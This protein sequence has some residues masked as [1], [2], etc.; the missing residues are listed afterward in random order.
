MAG[1]SLGTNLSGLDDWSTSYPFVNQFLMTRGWF[2]Q[3]ATEWD[4]GDAGLLD[5]DA[6]GWVRGFTDD[7]TAPPFQN[8]ASIWQTNGT[9]FRPGTYVLDWQGSGDVSISGNAT[10]LSQTDG[11]I[12]FRLNGPDAVGISLNSTDPGNTGDYVRDM[13]LYHADD[14]D[15]IEAGAIFNPA[16][17]ERIEDFRVLRFMDWGQTNN[18]TV[19]GIAD[20][21]PFD[22]ARQTGPGGASLELMVDLANQTRADAWFTIPHLADAA[23]IRTFATYVRDHL[24]PG[25]MARFEY[26]NE[27]WNWGFE[28]A[29]WAQQ[30]AVVTWGADVEGGWMQ[31]YGRQ[32]TTMAL[33]V[34]NVFGAE[35]GTRALNVF[36]TQSGW[37]GLEGYALDAPEWVA[38]GGL[39]PRDAP[40]H[41]YAIAPYFSGGVGSVDNAAQVDQWIAMGDAG[42]LAAIVYIRSG[43]DFDSL[44][45][46][47]STIAYHAGVAAASAGRLRLMRPGSTS[48][49]RKG[50]SAAR[51]TPHRP[52]SSSTWCAGPSFATCTWNTS[53]SGATRAAG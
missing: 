24:D 32:A 39:T 51:R 18:S 44:A 36:A 19:D 12:T 25:L 50:C 15:L 20:L 11:R 53:R 26:S 6:N 47:G 17:L 42:F 27:V 38:D 13:R 31:W 52:R 16:F 3:S 14:A 45:N 34:A 40:F 46:I 7:G 22:A 1:P 2:T 49:I 23:Y 48:S 5:L 33:I 21:R 35:T 10:L 43:P 29:Q 4:S 41:V 37:Q 28:Q 8:V 30:Q 9:I